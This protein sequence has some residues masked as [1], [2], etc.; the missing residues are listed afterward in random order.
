MSDKQCCKC[1]VTKAAPDFQRLASSLD[2]LQPRCRECQA[3]ASAAYWLRTKS[4]PVLKAARAVRRRAHYEANREAQIATATAWIAANRERF[5]QGAVAR[6]AATPEKFKALAKQYRQ[7]NP[8]KI[9]E[10]SARRRARKRLAFVEAV[11][12]QRVWDRDICICGLCGQW[13]G[14]P[15]SEDFT[16]DHLIPLAL[17][18]THEYR[19]VHAAHRACNQRKHLA[20]PSLEA[21]AAVADREE[22]LVA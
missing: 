12:P 5:N 3:A 14:P 8:A 19:N 10:F 16:L 17:G 20:M 9:N 13:V 18:G 21:L 15:G 7:A 4:D 2:G 11:D 6:Y 22:R 1:K